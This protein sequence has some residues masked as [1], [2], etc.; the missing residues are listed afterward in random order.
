MDDWFLRNADQFDNENRST[1]ISTAL[2]VV[3]TIGNAELDA[4]A[5]RQERAL[6][7]R[8]YKEFAAESR[9]EWLVHKLLGAGDASAFY[10]VPGCGK[11]VL[12]EDLALH[13]A[14]GRD[15]HG[16][17]IKRGAVLY[18]AL[19]RR[20]LVERRA[21]AFRNRRQIADIPFAVV[22]GMH[23]F[24]QSQTVGRIIEV[25]RELEDETGAAT[26]LIVID[27]ISRALAGGD[28][29]SPKDMGAIV[30]A[31]SLLQETKA[32][33]LWV[34]HMP[35]D[36]AERLRGHGA[37]LGAMDTTVHVEKLSD[38]M[39]GAT[40]MK[41]ND[42]EEHERVTFT[43]ESVEIGPETTAPVVVAADPLMVTATAKRSGRKIPDR[44]KLA[45]NALREAVL[46][47]GKPASPALQLPTG[48]R[49]VTITQWREE[50][51]RQ[52]VI[53]RDHKNPKVAFDR[54][55]ETLAA[56]SLIGIRDE[57]VWSVSEPNLT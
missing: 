16:R 9:K 42:S 13:V 33:I 57:E 56:R 5:V 34:H 51:F 41:A 27:T 35:Q 45:L 20:G 48:I 37:L 49:T 6:N 30:A 31:T 2:V 12:V 22:G 26:A 46:T 52:S 55:R 50:L 3:P 15:W 1:S 28:E 47:H 11:S 24:R 17:P 39:R 32:H 40:V 21:I 38:D 29:N 23:D 54:M 19:E 8:L 43:L 53:P 25:T 18:V 4:I 7:F 36:G 14:A 44:A 10:G